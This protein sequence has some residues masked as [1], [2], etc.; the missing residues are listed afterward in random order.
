MK[1]NN[2]QQLLTVAAIAVVALFA[3]DKL[4]FSPL[5]QFWKGRSKAIGELRER[6]TRGKNLQDREGALRSDWQRMRTNTLPTDE[7]LAE[8]QVLKA[9]RKWERDSRVTITSISPQSKHDAEEYTTIQCRVEASGTI[10]NMN[11]FLYDMEKDPMA[12][13]LELVELSSHDT[14]GQTLLLGLQVSGLI[15]A[16]PAQKQ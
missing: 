9:F 14:E 13:K 8:E 5:T 16:A 7:S 6:V 2:R 12:L 4:L 15:L 1:I 10:D 3:A 11:H